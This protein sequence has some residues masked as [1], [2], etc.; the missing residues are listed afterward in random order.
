MASLA[1]GLS[2]HTPKG[3]RCISSYF[4]EERVLLQSSVMMSEPR[5]LS[6]GDSQASC[7]LGS[8][9]WLVFNAVWRVRN[10]IGSVEGLIPV[11]DRT[12]CFEFLFRGRS[13]QMGMPLTLK[14]LEASVELSLLHF[15]VASA[16]NLFIDSH[17]VS[18]EIPASCCSFLKPHPRQR[19]LPK[20]RNGGCSTLPCQLAVSSVSSHPLTRG[21]TVVL[22]RRVSQPMSRQLPSL[23][24][25]VVQRI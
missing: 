23:H 1:F 2:I 18:T 25:A 11:G 16:A 19:P 10:W 13:D 21:A 22:Q 8:S 9:A 17:H 20:V 12:V 7:L 4:P 24:C 15:V 3:E 5:W 14:R 6:S